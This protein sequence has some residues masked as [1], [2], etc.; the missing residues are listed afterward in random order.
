MTLR[1]PVWPSIGDLMLVYVRETRALAT[2]ASCASS[3]AR[4]VDRRA[5]RLDRR[6][7]GVGLGPRLLHLI[8][9]EDAALSELGLALE[10]EL[11]VL[12]V[13]RV[14]CEL[15]DGLLEQR[16]VARQV[17]FGLR[18]RGLKRTPIEDEE[19]LSLRDEA[20]LVEGELGEQAGHL[21]ADRDGRVGLDVADGGQVDR[22]VLLGGLGRDHWRRAPVAAASTAAAA[23]AARRGRRCFAAARAAG[24]G[25][26]DEKRPDADASNHSVLPLCSAQRTSVTHTGILGRAPGYLRDAC[27]LMSLCG[28]LAV[29]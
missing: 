24:G 11:L 22:D 8:L 6:R 25:R 26:G 9:R 18:Q 19:R 23:R 28:L 29:S 3:C 17:R 10:R 5:I 15:R 16:L 14:A 4:A 12:G 21:R 1:A 7:G 20:A 27:H 2:A 13:G